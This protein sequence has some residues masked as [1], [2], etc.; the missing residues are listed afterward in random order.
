MINNL[1]LI[2]LSIRLIV[3]QK[4]GRYQSLPNFYCME[5]HMLDLEKKKKE[6]MLA[7]VT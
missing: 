3:Q 7:K 5:S 6:G 4:K 1:S 2:S